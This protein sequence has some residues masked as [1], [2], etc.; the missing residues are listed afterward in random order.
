MKKDKRIEVVLW[1]VALPGVGQFLNNKY[2]KGAVIIFLEFLINV[3]ARLNEVILPSFHGDIHKAIA[4]A[5]YH[6]LM[7]YPCFYM[8]SIYDA[9]KDAGGGKTEPFAY[10]P[11]VVSAFVGTVGVVYSPIFNINGYYF[12]G[13]WLPIIFHI[14][15]FFTGLLFKR[16]LLNIYP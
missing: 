7:F 3:Q 10:L 5:D 16:R 11:F 12:G 13:V 1:S 8:F 6:W 9:Y 15:G 14:I 2:F 4:G